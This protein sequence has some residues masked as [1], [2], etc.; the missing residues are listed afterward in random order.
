MFSSENGSSSRTGAS[1]TSA[2]S[3]VAVAEWFMAS[4]LAGQNADRHLADAPADVGAPEAQ[5]VLAEHRDLAGAVAPVGD[6]RARMAHGVVGAGAGHHVEV[7]HLVV[8]ALPE[9]LLHHLLHQ[10][11]QLVASAE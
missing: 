11:E 2:T 6:E 8:H 1:T 10:R 3:A 4:L 5:V 9:F 7:G